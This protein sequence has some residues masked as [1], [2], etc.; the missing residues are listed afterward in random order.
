MTWRKNQS[1]EPLHGGP[2]LALL[3]DG[4][5]FLA[6]ISPGDSGDYECQ[7]TNE[8]GSASRS[9]RLLVHGK[10]GPR[11]LLGRRDGSG[12]RTKHRLHMPSS[13]SSTTKCGTKPNQKTVS[14]HM[15]ASGDPCHPDNGVDLLILG[16]PVS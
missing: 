6:S 4:S 11:Y 5:L 3:A 15:I 13:I 9:T 8:A 10:Q 14:F 16:T 12:S 2:G 1:G 7:A